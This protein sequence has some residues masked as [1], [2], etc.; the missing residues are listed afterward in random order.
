VKKKR[1]RTKAGA[2]SRDKA[3][4][5]NTGEKKSA[6]TGSALRVALRLHE[7]E[8]LAVPLYG[9][10]DSR[11]ECDF[12][13]YYKDKDCDRPGRHPRVQGQEVAI[14]YDQDIRRWW[15]QWPDASPGIVIDRKL[16]AVVSE[17]DAGKST[18]RQLRE[19]NKRFKK[20]ITIRDGARTIRLYDSFGC[21]WRHGTEL[22][23]GLRL[24]NDGEIVKAPTRLKGGQGVTFR[25][26]SAPGEAKLA[27]P[28]DWLVHQ[29][30]VRTAS[31]FEYGVVRVEDVLTPK[32]H[33][34]A[35]EE[36]VS[37]IAESPIGPF[38]PIIVRRIPGQARKV[39]L[40]RG[41]QRLDAA[42]LRGMPTIACYFFTGTPTTA[43]ILA[44]E[45]DAFRKRLTRLRKAELLDEWAKLMPVL[46]YRISGQLGRKK[47]GRPPKYIPELGVVGRSAEARRKI[48][49][50]ASKI[51]AI[52]QEAKNVAIAGG[53]ANNQQA[54]LAIAKAGPGK[55]V[56]KAKDLVANRKERMGK[57]TIGPVSPPLQPGSD[58][59]AEPSADGQDA[60]DESDSRQVPKETTFDEIDRLWKRAGG[61]KLWRYAPFAV[62]MEFKEKLDRATARSDVAE[63]INKV[64]FGRKEVDVRQLYAYAKTQGIQRKVL[65][66]NLRALGFK[67]SK[68]G[69][70]PAA[71]RFYR[72]KN[73]IWKDQLQVI[74]DAELEAPLAAEQKETSVEQQYESD[75]ADS[76]VNK[77]YD[78][79]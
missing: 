14:A 37:A 73:S 44:L 71:P 3:R 63:F 30:S 66:I 32:G 26:G 35:E 74:T 18:E 29:V 31:M 13:G 56:K 24:L 45:E 62:R 8:V 38:N 25:N 49:G 2:K 1:K 50:N 78:D 58:R 12:S 28:P 75:G 48:F 57:A 55:E 10:V 20:T 16:I 40:I 51:A 41:K 6:W 61:P 65:P 60:D 54:L 27:R 5:Q 39:E 79:I 46:G 43:R 15:K 21:E 67:L 76:P 68:H 47:R 59:G 19:Q 70:H 4:V 36:V 22:G 42:R 52:S 72:N 9:E 33:D 64:F 34:E 17:G 7:Q 11:C 77:Y 53:L 69:H 23:A